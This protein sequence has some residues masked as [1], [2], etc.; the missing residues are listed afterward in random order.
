MEFSPDEIRALANKLAEIIIPQLEETIK[1]KA[2]WTVSEMSKLEGRWL[3]VAELCELFSISDRHVRN[4]IKAGLP[5]VWVGGTI[6]IEKGVLEQ[7]IADG[8][9]T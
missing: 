8:K 6:R 7:A 5:H 1:S 2:R 3:S 9:L 4:L